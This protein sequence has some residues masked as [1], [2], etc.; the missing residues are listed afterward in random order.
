MEKSKLKSWISFRVKPKEYDIIHAQFQKTTCRKLSEYARKVLLNKPVVVKY[1]NLSADDFL[2]DMIKLKNELSA[3]GNNFNQ[4]VKRLH[5]LD[6]FPEVR[7]WLTTSEPGIN[8]AINK[9]EEIK[10][11]MNQVYEI[12]SQK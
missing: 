5:T 11:R 3:V 8:A 10:S 1:R 6:K 4:A 12:W 7:S 9:I 2:R